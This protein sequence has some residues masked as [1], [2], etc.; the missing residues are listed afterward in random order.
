MRSNLRINEIKEK[1]GESL[2][3]YR[4]DVEKLFRYKL[5][6]KEKK[7]HRYSPQSKKEFS[8]ETLEQRKEV[9]KEVIIVRLLSQKRIKS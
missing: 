7:Y 8:K 1:D 9:R 2:G 6:I 5:D 4:A 3:D